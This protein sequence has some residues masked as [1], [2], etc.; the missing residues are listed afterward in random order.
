MNQLKDIDMRRV[1]KIDISS[2]CHSSIKENICQHNI[3]IEYT[4]GVV[5]TKFFVNSRELLKYTN[6][7]SQ[8]GIKH[9]R[10]MD[11]TFIHHKTKKNG[12]H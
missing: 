7:L 2:V 9:V 1:K 5:L 4:E 10:E 12:T 8:G 3:Y 11:T 6:K